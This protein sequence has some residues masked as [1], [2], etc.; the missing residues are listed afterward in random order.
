MNTK[1]KVF[2]ITF[3]KN[4]PFQR[5]L[6]KFSAICCRFRFSR[7][8]YLK[9]AQNFASIWK[10]KFLNIT[11]LNFRPSQPDFRK[12]SRWSCR[13]FDSGPV[14]LKS[15]SNFTLIKKKI[16]Q[17]KIVL[18]F[19]PSQPVFSSFDYEVVV[20]LTRDWFHWIQRRISHRFKKKN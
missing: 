18:K 5:R 4:R 13:L 15:A 9:S 1:K 3:L 14:P 17:K 10:K 2:N 8:V 19:R 20:F 7:N 11:I 6:F 16:F 12:I